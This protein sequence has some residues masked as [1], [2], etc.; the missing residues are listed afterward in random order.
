MSGF[1]RLLYFIKSEIALNVAVLRV[2]VAPVYASPGAGLH[3][4]KDYGNKTTHQSLPENVGHGRPYCFFQLSPVGCATRLYAISAQALE[5]SMSGIHTCF[6]S[7]SFQWAAM[8]IQ[9]SCS[10]MNRP[11]E[12][13]HA[14]TSSMN[15]A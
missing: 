7:A 9:H 10:S 5:S 4:C 11:V 1:A 2:L 14:F 12:S 15:G 8:K 6:V 13:Y 3:P